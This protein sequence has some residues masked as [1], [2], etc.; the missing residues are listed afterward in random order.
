MPRSKNKVTR[1][2]PCK[3][4]VTN[5]VREVIEQ[6]MSIRK[7]SEAFQ[8]SKTL[9]GRYVKKQKEAEGGEFVYEPHNDVKRVFTDQE[10]KQL[11]D[12]CLKASKFH[13]G[14]SKEEFLKLVYEFAVLLN[15]PY[16]QVWNENKMAG[17]TFYQYFIKRHQ[18][19]SLRKPEAT[20]L[21][22]ATAFNKANVE[23]F[24]TKYTE[25]LSRFNF[26]SDRIYNVDESGLS[27]VHTPMKV[28]A[29]KGTKQVGNITSAER[30]NNVTVIGCVNALGNSVPPCMI[31]PRVHFKDHM[32]NGAPPET[33]GLA[34]PSGWSNSE[35][36]EV[37]LQH[38]IKH[39]KP[40]NE[41]KVLLIL[42]NHE[43]HLSIK[44]IDL[45]KKNGIVMFT[46]PPHTSHKLQPLDRTVFGPL[47]KYY[48]KA[49]NEWLLQHPGSPLTIYHVAE[50]FGKAYPLAFT[51]SNIQSGFRVSG[52]WPINENIFGEDEFLS[53]YVTDRPLNENAC[54]NVENITNN[55]STSSNIQ[56]NIPNNDQN[57]DAALQ[58]NIALSGPSTSACENQPSDGIPELLKSPEI[59]RPFPKAPP[60]K[61]IKA[62]N[63]KGKTRVLTDTPEKQELELAAKK[64]KKA[65]TKKK[66]T[67]KKRVF[68]K[69]NTSR[70][71]DETDLILES[72]ESG[73][74]VHDNNICVGCG[75]NYFETSSKEDWV[76]CIIC[77]SWFHEDCTIFDN[78]CQK[79]GIR[80]MRQP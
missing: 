58:E 3:E 44:I 20:S 13:Y 21:G 41:N 19:L 36:F 45:A 60:R 9:I 61:N 49:C 26:T 43:S 27:T 47:K 28:L 24:F 66:K 8:V 37:F 71:E 67:V 59:V 31:F 70:A 69:D 50:C 51:P 54:T 39:A 2:K 22:R 33:L 5:A 35:K 16:P 64:R 10:E 40:N 56:T 55:Q 34:N 42:D 77:H 25:L 48:N 74:S 15:K 17:K 6:R 65:V 53:S 7:A 68:E 76:Q 78:Y 63:R 80:K 4:N 79:C 32:I 62:K 73:D 72:D 14:I 46:F 75:E 23:L 11:V 57:P 30:G 1:P 29:P 18:N 38:F 52:I 12:Y